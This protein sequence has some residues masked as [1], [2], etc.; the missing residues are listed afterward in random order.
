MAFKRSAVRSRLSPPERPVILGL[1]VFF[2]CVD[3]IRRKQQATP[4][5]NGVACCVLL[6]NLHARTGGRCSSIQRVQL[7]SY[8][9]PMD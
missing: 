7:S 2:L 8:T 6:D 4:D 1:Q 5:A 3:S 9:G